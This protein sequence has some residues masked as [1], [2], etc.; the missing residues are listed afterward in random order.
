MWF[1]FQ[2]SNRRRKHVRQLV[3]C[4]IV[5]L[6]LAVA[7]G[8]SAADA[9]LMAPIQKFIDSFN[10]GDVAGAAATH[11]TTA[12]LTIVDEVPPH[13]WNGPK[14]FQSWSADLDADAKKAGLTEP[15][16]TLGA[17]TRVESDGEQAYVVVPAV[18]SFKQ[19]GKAMS[20]KAQMT[21]VLK[22]GASGWLIHA[23]TWTGR[24]PS[25]AGP[26]PA[27]SKP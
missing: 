1:K 5:A 24:K 3:S 16:V 11:S 12:D 23:W 10:K 17:P 2:P 13:L 8:A 19:N 4:A 21:F 22:K 27:K 14:A 25:P 20:E 15:A 6:V 26:A 7:A 9:Q 18:Y